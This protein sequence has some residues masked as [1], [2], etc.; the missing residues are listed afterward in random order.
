MCLVVKEYGNT[1]IYT[2]NVGDSRAVLKHGK[3]GAI[4][5]ST[6]HRPCERE[7]LERIAKAGGVIMGGR[8]G[9]SLAITRALGDHILFKSGVIPNPSISRHEVKRSDTY[10]VIASD[11]VWDALSDEVREV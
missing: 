8:V 7:E 1:V 5:L 2:A 10:L 9:G 11:G 3:S 6:D 4:R